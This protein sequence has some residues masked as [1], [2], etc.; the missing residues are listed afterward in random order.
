MALKCV[1]PW[2]LLCAIEET[3]SQLVCRI[4]VFFNNQYI[5]E[6]PLFQHLFFIFLVLSLQNHQ[7]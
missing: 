6:K 7:N 4:T 1:C 3:Y 2:Q 5:Y